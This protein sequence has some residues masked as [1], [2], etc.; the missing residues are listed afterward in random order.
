MRHNSGFS[1]LLKDTSACRFFGKTGDRTADLQVGGWPLFPHSCPSLVRYISGT[2]SGN[3]FKFG[4]KC[5]LELRDKLVRIWWSEVKVTVTS[6]IIFLAS[7]SVFRKRPRLLTCCLLDPKINW[8][9]F[10]LSKVTLTSD[11]IEC[12]I[13][14]TPGGIK[15]ALVGRR[16]ELQG[17]N[18]VYLCFIHSMLQY[19]IVG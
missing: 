11:N 17:G 18:L 15:T 9:D 19:E 10:G 13:S 4:S 3:F 16:I 2:P 8:L 6:K 5:S 14:G 7:K 12:N 1:I